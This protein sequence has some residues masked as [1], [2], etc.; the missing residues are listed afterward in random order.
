MIFHL[1]NYDKKYR[2]AFPEGPK[3]CT[4]L[5]ITHLSDEGVNGDKNGFTGA[6]VGLSAQDR[7][8]ES[9]WAEVDYFDCRSLAGDKNNTE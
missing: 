7:L 6:F 2:Y 3:L 1:E 4:C 8:Y 9:C 5:S